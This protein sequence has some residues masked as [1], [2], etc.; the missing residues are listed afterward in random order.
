MNDSLTNHAIPGADPAMNEEG[1][2][3]FISAPA[4][5]P[6]RKLSTLL[7]LAG[8]RDGTTA[9]PRTYSRAHADFNNVTV[10]ST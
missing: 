7:S 9:C 4:A 3:T 5:E 8:D 10:P 6:R 1:P 2:T